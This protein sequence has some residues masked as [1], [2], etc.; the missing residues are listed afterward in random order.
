MS[1]LYLNKKESRY[2]VKQSLRLLSSEMLRQFSIFCNF[3][4]PN[5]SDTACIMVVKWNSI[6]YLFCDVDDWKDYY[7]SI[8][9]KEKNAVIMVCDVTKGFE[10]PIK[11]RYYYVVNENAKTFFIDNQN[12]NN[13]E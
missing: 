9:Q 8:A 10:K 2:E 6:Q 3:R 11:I 7:S 4:V 5:N 12:I 13:Y 1:Y